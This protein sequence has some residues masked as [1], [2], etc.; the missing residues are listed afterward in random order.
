MLYPTL[1]GKMSVIIRA[2]YFFAIIIFMTTIY[3]IMTSASSVYREIKL[4]NKL[5][6][7]FIIKCDKIPLK[8]KLKV[9]LK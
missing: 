9:I 5:L 6:N 7:Q 8:L 2:I 1:Y 3:L 4:T